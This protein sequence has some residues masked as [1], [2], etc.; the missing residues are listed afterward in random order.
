MRTSITAGALSAVLLLVAAIAPAT[1]SGAAAQRLITTGGA[2]VGHVACATNGLCVAAQATHIRSSLNWGATWRDSDTLLASEVVAGAACTTS[3]CFVVS[4]SVQGAFVG[5]TVDGIKWK[6]AGMGETTSVSVSCGSST[7]TAVLVD[8][9]ETGPL[10]ARFS[11]TLANPSGFTLEGESPENAV[12]D[13]ACP[14]NINCIAVGQGDSP[15]L[16]LKFSS[17]SE[18]W[19]GRCETTSTGCRDAY[20]Q[21]ACFGRTCVAVAGSARLYSSSDVGL[22]W[23]RRASLTGVT[24]HSI[25]CISSAICV[26]V[27]SGGKIYRS[28]DSGRTWR[29]VASPTTRILRSVSCTSTGRCIAAGDAGTL[30]RTTSNGSSWSLRPALP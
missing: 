12:N 21:V 26:A 16:K 18:T 22:A 29:S 13:I 2:R 15:V 28:T 6:W 20:R 24:F 1:A 25:S 9:D 10:L 17:G 4:N 5:R 19:I 27:G 3:T 14:D 23:T 30:I 11:S 7:C 8:P